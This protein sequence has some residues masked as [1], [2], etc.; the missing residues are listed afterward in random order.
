LTLPVGSTGVYYPEGQLP[1]IAGGSPEGAQAHRSG[2][3]PTTERATGEPGAVQPDPPKWP[4]PPKWGGP[5][6]CSWNAATNTA[7]QHTCEGPG[8]LQRYFLPVG[9]RPL[10]A[11]LAADPGPNKLSG[12]FSSSFLVPPK[13]FPTV[14][15]RGGGTAKRR[16]TTTHPAS[17]PFLPRH[18][19][20]KARPLEQSGPHTGT[21]THV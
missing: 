8:A 1:H 11:L 2:P 7:S 6:K 3:S 5:P 14:Q 18:V 13:R 12:D 21:L 9:R 17:G 16:L 10:P 15:P 19:A 20:L 4:G